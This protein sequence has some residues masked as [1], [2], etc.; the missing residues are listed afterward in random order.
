V[1]DVEIEQKIEAAFQAAHERNPWVEGHE[2]ALLSALRPQIR[3]LLDQQA[4]EIAEAIEEEADELDVGLQPAD[5]WDAHQYFKQR[6]HDMAAIAYAR[7]G[8]Q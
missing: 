5:H 3:L 6:F 4:K 1:S 2:E 8:D 7:G